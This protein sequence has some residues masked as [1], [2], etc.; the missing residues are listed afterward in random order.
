MAPRRARAATSSRVATAL[1]LGLL[2]NLQAKWELDLAWTRV[3]RRGP[4]QRSQRPR[5]RR[6]QPSSTRSDTGRRTSSMKAPAQRSGSAVAGACGASPRRRGHAASARRKPR[7]SARELTPMGAEKAAN[8]DGTIPEWTGGIKSPARGRL[9]RT[10]RPGSIIR[11][12]Y[13][14]DKPLFTITPENMGAVRRASSRRDTR[15]CCSTYKS[16]YKMMVYPTHRSAAFPQR[17]YDATKRVATTANLALAATASR[18]RS[19][20]FR[21]RFPTQGVEVFWNH[22]L[23]YRADTAQRSIGQAPVT[24]ER[25]LHAGEVPRRVPVPVHACRA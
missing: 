22:V 20:A 4:L 5:F 19:R 9:S 8:A 14:N 1:T 7:S 23:R 21:S 25:R 13:A 18:A 3:R 12:P 11:D 24:R 15:S 16:T 17:I 6:G 2:A 10:I